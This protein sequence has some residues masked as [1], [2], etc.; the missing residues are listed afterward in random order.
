MHL[1]FNLYSCKWSFTYTNIIE[2]EILSWQANIKE[3]KEIKNKPE[4]MN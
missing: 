3:R 4:A 2:K 1:K